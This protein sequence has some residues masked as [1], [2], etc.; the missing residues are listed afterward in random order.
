MFLEIERATPA[1]AT[2]LA[3]VFQAAFSDEFNRQM[4]PATAEV[5]DWL[6][7][8][9]LNGNGDAPP[10]QV[11]LKIADSAGTGELVGFAKWIMPGTAEDAARADQDGDKAPEWPIG[12]DGDLC[13]RFFGGMRANHVRIMGDR[14]HYCQ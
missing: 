1:D 7:K 13:E 9:L 14:P 2:R 5:G 12:S 8:N 3:G 11:I 10:R 6:A 4:F